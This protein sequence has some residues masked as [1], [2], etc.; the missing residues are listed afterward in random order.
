MT[1][2]QFIKGNEEIARKLAGKRLAEVDKLFQ[3]HISKIIKLYQINNNLDALTPQIKKEFEKISK[4]LASELEDLI[5]TATKEQWISAQS[6]ANKFVDTYFDVTALKLATQQIYRTENL[7]EYFKAQKSRLNKFKLSNR[8]WK[9]SN[10][11][12]K[13]MQDAFEV[14]LLN[15][16]SA[17]KL[18]RDIKQYLNDPE[19]LFRRVRDSKGQLHLSKNAK[20]YNP[21]QGVYRSSHKNALRLASSEINAYYKT[22]ENQRWQSMDFVVGFEIKRSNNVYNCDV[23]DSLKGKYPKTFKFAS[24]HP[25]C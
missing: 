11:F 5:N 7:K 24:W 10:Q 1:I 21:G 16:D 15:G 6:T 2:V 25:N 22:S 12:E 17:Q 4:E 14:A 18:S 8:V 23:C 13:Q 20:L 9:Y 19:T 3:K